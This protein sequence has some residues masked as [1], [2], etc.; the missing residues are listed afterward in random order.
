MPARGLLI[1][2]PAEV[3]ARSL[4]NE[5]LPL[6]RDDVLP[7][8]DIVFLPYSYFSALVFCVVGRQISSEK[9]IK[10]LHKRSAQCFDKRGL[11]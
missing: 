7:L 10:D 4:K 2:K 11:S 9:K 6:N 5:C 1:S 8:M 3:I